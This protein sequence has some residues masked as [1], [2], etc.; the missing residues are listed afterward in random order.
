M[1]DTKK[2]R[3]MTKLAV[4]EG[5]EGKSDLAIHGYTEGNY[6]NLQMIKSIICVTIGY[7]ILLILGCFRYYSES[8]SRAFVL[9][10]RGFIIPAIIMYIFLLISTIIFSRRLYRERF[11]QMKIRVREYD[12]NL[13]RLR[14]HIDEKKKQ[15]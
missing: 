13:N 12:R 3:L 2:I 7:G 15:I 10:Q 14:K 5:N 8:A 11:R 4:Y 9:S 6:V 1:L